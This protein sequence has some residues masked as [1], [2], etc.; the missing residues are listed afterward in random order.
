M[1]RPEGL[2]APHVPASAYDEEYFLHGC[3]GADEWR[4]SGGRDAA[5]LYEAML[6]RASMRPGMRLLDIG[7]GRGEL[8]VAAL[9]LGAEQ[10]VGVDYS[11]AAIDLARQTLAAAGAPAAAE[12]LRADARRLPVD[13]SRFDLVT[14]LDVVE[15]LSAPELELSLAEAHRA[16]RPGGAVFVHTMPNRLVYDV[17]YRLQRGLLPSRRRRW[18][19]DPRNELE[20]RMHVGEQ[21]PGTLRSA[22]RRARF[23]EV[24]VRP[25]DWVYTDFVPEQGPRATYHRLARVPLLRRIAI[26]DL[27]ATARKPSP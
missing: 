20:R 23:E 8:L 17:T 9:E 1:P 6:R 11:A 22:L 7:T 14:M 4:E 24:E 10:A 21:S 5:G 12:A 2:S 15:H 18:P 27:Y 26:A 19:A 16:L 13:D 25:G 3:M